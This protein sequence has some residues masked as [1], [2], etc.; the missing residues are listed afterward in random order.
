MT[1]M[2]VYVMPAHLDCL[3]PPI[4]IGESDCLAGAIALAVA[5]GY[6]IIAEGESGCYETYDHA[7]GPGIFGYPPDNRGVLGITVMPAIA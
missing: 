2:H 1:M 5:K 4:A 3:D 7:D 6:E